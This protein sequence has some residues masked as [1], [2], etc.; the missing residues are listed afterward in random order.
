MHILPRATVQELRGHIDKIAHYLRGIQDHVN[1]IN[2]IKPRLNPMAPI[3]RIPP[4]LLTEIFLCNMA[5]HIADGS[6][7]YPLQ[8]P[9]W[10][11]VTGVCRHWREV[12]LLCSQ[13]WTA[14]SL[15][16]TIPK[17]AGLEMDD[18]FLSR[19]GQSHLLVRA[20]LSP[21]CAQFI[22][23][24]ISRIKALQLAVISANE[25]TFTLISSA[26]ALKRLELDAHNNEGAFGARAFVDRAGH[27]CLR[28]VYGNEALRLE[29]LV[30]KSI[31]FTWRHEFHHPNLRTLSI[32]L[33]SV[34][35]RG[36]GPL[37]CILAALR[38]MPLLE[39]LVLQNCLPDDIPLSIP[40]D[41]P[42]VRLR[43][44]RV[45]SLRAATFRC[46][47]L[48]S[49]LEFPPEISIHLC[50]DISMTLETSCLRRYQSHWDALYPVQHL[51]LD[52]P[53]IILYPITECHVHDW[54]TSP[55]RLTWIDT[56]QR[57]ACRLVINAEFYR[58][59]AIEHMLKIL[60]FSHIVK[61]RYQSWHMSTALKKRFIST[62]AHVDILVLRCQD[63]LI[64]L[65][66]D[67]DR[68]SPDDVERGAELWP[69]PRLRELTLDY[70]FDL[71]PAPEFQSKQHEAII[72][73]LDRRRNCGLR[74]KTVKVTWQTPGDEAGAI[75]LQNRIQEVNRDDLE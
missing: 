65:G 1:A 7:W 75:A 47:N 51:V 27:P 67:L 39:A 31:N 69:F 37:D 28:I 53:N 16:H 58:G 9:D 21:Y 20:A 60:N 15:P 49:Y 25:R 32:Q 6:R 62:L 56:H 52:S 14:I 17:L 38:G 73:L 50:A 55:G 23:T 22:E 70:D 59:R 42:I 35:R 54:R 33:Q 24:H 44:L 45:L 4:E 8:R 26:T 41:H 5:L 48:I 29:V 18:P 64:V 11:H 13:L 12:T 66:T 74:I 71:P 3:S 10:L 36:M 40:H 43:H 19:S 72:S 63:A 61:L 30:L 46:T 2:A 68:D 34:P 57:A